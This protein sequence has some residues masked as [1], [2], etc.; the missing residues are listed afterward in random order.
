MGVP[1]SHSLLA[2]VTGSV[3]VDHKMGGLVPYPLL[4]DLQYSH[5]DNKKIRS[6]G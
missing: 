5:H 1:H 3:L 6:Q 4:L 2:G